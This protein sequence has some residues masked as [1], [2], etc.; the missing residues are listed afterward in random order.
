VECAWTRG[1]VHGNDRA[2]SDQLPC[3]LTCVREP[4][5]GGAG[6]RSMPRGDAHRRWAAIP[7]RIEEGDEDTDATAS[8]DSYTP[9]P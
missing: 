5:A 1:T 9:T 2:Q 6:D 8:D 3:P 4:D 7:D